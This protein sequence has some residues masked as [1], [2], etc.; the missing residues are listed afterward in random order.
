M[1][2]YELL[3]IGYG[4]DT[5]EG[6][7]DRLGCFLNP[8]NVIVMDV[9]RLDCKSRNGRWAWWGACMESTIEEVGMT[10]ASWYKLA[11]PYGRTRGLEQYARAIATSGELR[12]T[13]CDLKWYIASLDMKVCLLCAERKPYVGNRPNCH[14]VI[15]AER[16][17]LEL[18]VR[19]GTDILWSVTHVE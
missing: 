18:N 6:F 13:F 4:R 2:H 8:G 11:N 5:K 10:Y 1:K 15:L 7:Q 17:V 3:T 12:D 16:L 14:R 9:R 19:T